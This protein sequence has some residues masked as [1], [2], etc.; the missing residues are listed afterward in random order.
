MIEMIWQVFWLVPLP[1][2]LPI[3]QLTDSGLKFAGMN[4]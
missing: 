2:D 1:A 4:D 3:H